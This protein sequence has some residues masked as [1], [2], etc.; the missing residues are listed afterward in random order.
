LEGRKVFFPQ[1]KTVEGCLPPPGGKRRGSLKH[2][3]GSRVVR[4]GD[5][6]REKRKSSIGEKL[7]LQKERT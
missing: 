1:G 5:A 7:I 3:G 4:K 2:T 6:R